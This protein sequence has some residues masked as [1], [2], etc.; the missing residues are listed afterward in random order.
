MWERS[1]LSFS[2]LPYSSCMMTTL[3]FRLI[4]E[5]QAWKYF[6]FLSPTFS[7]NTRDR[8]QTCTSFL[9][10]LT[11][12]E[13]ARPWSNSWIVFNHS[14][15][16]CNF[17]WTLPKLHL[18]HW[19]NSKLHRLIRPITSIMSLSHQATAQVSSIISKYS[20]SSIHIASKHNYLKPLRLSIMPPLSIQRGGW[21]EWAA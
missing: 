20:F 17:F 21:S 8:F 13:F 10:S 15:A 14:F 6:E 5:A 7:H 1:W 9:A 3:F 11:I 16:S 2:H 19:L 4:F 12:L 18:F